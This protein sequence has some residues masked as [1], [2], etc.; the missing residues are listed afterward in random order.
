MT[1]PQCGAPLPPE[2]VICD[3]CGSR[4]N[5]DL[6][7]W[8]TAEAASEGEDLHCADGHGPLVAIRVA[9]A[10][11]PAFHRCDTC[12]GLFLGRGA[13]EHW[14][15]QA[16]GPVWEVNRP[17][18]Q[19]LI[20]HPRHR[21]EQLRYRPCPRCGELMHR[22]LFGRRSGVIVDRC[23]SHGTWL[24]AGE[25]R[26]LMEWA[27]AGGHL[28]QQE[29]AEEER[30]QEDRRRREEQ[31][32]RAAVLRELDRSALPLASVEDAL[33]LRLARALVSLGQRP[34]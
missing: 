9:I 11:A 23:R 15:R 31:D 30:R 34:R 10:G 24:D 6:Q 14:L 25:L 7:G 13:L 5:V 20:E 29:R 1:C 28:L 26:Q 8:A 33:L 12:L 21:S 19:H 18:I 16:V 27:R 2:G 32:R 3:Y 22:S 17:L 4:Q